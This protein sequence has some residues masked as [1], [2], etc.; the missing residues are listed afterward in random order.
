MGDKITQEIMRLY[1]CCENRA[2]EIISYFQI[3]NEN[4]LEN[5]IEL[6]AR[7]ILKNIKE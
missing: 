5:H 3:D 4:K 2:Q 1:N 6:L 7:T